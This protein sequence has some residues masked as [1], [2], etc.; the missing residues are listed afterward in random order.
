MLQYLLFPPD[1]PL[2]HPE[3]SAQM[4]PHESCGALHRFLVAQQDHPA[5][6]NFTAQ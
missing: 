4:E 3:E 1:G 6:V 2:S 5:G